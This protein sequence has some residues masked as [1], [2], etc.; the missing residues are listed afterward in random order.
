MVSYFGDLFNG[1]L[2]WGGDETR[3]GYVQYVEAIYPNIPER[4]TFIDICAVVNQL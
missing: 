2:F 1:L 4:T 3:S